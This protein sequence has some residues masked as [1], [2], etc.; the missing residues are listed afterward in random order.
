[1]FLLY[2]DYY[3]KRIVLVGAGHTHIE[4]ALR[5][6][7]IVSDGHELVL[8][9]PYRMHPYSGMGPGLLSGTYSAADVLLPAARL[10][11]EGG[12]RFIDDRVTGMDP[13]RRVL[14]LEDTGELSYDL[15]SFNLG[16]E[17]FD[18]PGGAD[19]FAVKPIS[20]LAEAR[21][22]IERRAMRQ[23]SVRI[24][25][26]GGGPGGVELAGNSAHLL[27]RLQVAK[28]EIALYTGSGTLG[29][30][31][32][33]RERF[34]EKRLLG[35]G[36]TIYRGERRRPDELDS[37]VVLLASGIRPPKVQ[38]KLGLPLSADGGIRI[39]RYLR[40]VSF[41]QVFAVGDCATFEEHPLDRVGVFAVR[42][43]PVLLENLKRSAAAGSSEEPR[44][45]NPGNAG[46]PEHA[47]PPANGGTAGNSDNGLIPFVGTH[48]YLAGFNLGFGHGL[49]YRGRWTLWGR[50]AF[51]LKN[52]LDRKFM[53]RF[54][55]AVAR[56]RA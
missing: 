29:G 6:A 48:V 24:A 56:A 51:K 55:S 22:A 3:M 28:P 8:I 21:T 40:S 23:R 5:S 11:E 45:G 50:P 32:G 9:N 42:M 44:A 43:Q 4:L 20:N 14:T 39:D 37:D 30:V 33:E 12:G 25:V 26:I 52:Y 34:V 16:S 7:E 35:S 54:Q 46:S 38:E 1:M 13:Q 53:A 36:V 47:N 49:L 19:H 10:V 18:V 31:S 2:S 27:S 15:V 17:P 41:P